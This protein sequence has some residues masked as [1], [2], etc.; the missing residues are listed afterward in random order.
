MVLIALMEKSLT[1]GRQDLA[2]AELSARFH[3]S[4]CRQKGPRKFGKS[5]YLVG[6][7]ASGRPISM[8]GTVGIRKSPGSRPFLNVRQDDFS[9]LGNASGGDIGTRRRGLIQQH[10]E[11]W[12]YH[13]VHDR[14]SACTHKTPRNTL[15]DGL[16]HAG[17]L[18]QRS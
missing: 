5:I 12:H 1:K 7:L 6:L 3:R 14:E 17:S 4:V 13:E 2:V 8:N 16:R 10:Q 18:L 15:F 11:T 9:G